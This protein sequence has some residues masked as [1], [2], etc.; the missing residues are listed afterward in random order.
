MG[1]DTSSYSG[2]TDWGQIERLANDTSGMIPP[3]IQECMKKLLQN[4]ECIE[5]VTEMAEDM[6]V[7][8]NDLS[9]DD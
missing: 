6:G 3:D 5:K 9:F 8:P 1:V 4:R 7:D 2:D